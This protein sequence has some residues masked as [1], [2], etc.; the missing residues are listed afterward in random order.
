MRDNQTPPTL[1]P[2]SPGG[3]EVDGLSLEQWSNTQ[4][5]LEVIANTYNTPDAVVLLDQHVLTRNTYAKEWDPKKQKMV[6]SLVDGKK[7]VLK[8]K[9]VDMCNPVVYDICTGNELYGNHT[10]IYGKPG[11][12]DRPSLAEIV[13]SSSTTQCYL[14]FPTLMVERPPIKQCP[15]WDPKQQTLVTKTKWASYDT[16]DIAAA[17]C[18][19]IDVDGH[20]LEDTD[21]LEENPKAI[22]QLLRILPNYCAKTNIPMPAIVNSGRGIHLYWWFGRI[23]PLETDEQRYTFRVMLY[24]MGQ[25]IAKLIEAD[26]LCSRVWKVDHAAHSL[27]RMLHLPGCIHP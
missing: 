19:W 14:Y 23:A 12:N 20:H 15:E 10:Y 25:W 4:A 1:A 5:L 11:H 17:R 9:G 21:I 8:T 3:F 26:P 16:S 18:M 2:I 27:L 6:N 7:V 13:L 22:E 24:K